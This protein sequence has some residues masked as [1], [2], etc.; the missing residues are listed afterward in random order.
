MA[1][2]ILP[3]SA[4]VR[5]FPPPGSQHAAQALRD[6]LLSGLNFTWELVPFLS[7]SRVLSL[8]HLWVWSDVIRDQ[9]RPHKE[10]N[11]LKRGRCKYFLP[12]ITGEGLRWCKGSKREGAGAVCVCVCVKLQRRQDLTWAV[13]EKSTLVFKTNHNSPH[14]PPGGASSPRYLCCL[15]GASQEVAHGPW[16]WRPDATTTVRRGACKNEVFTGQRSAEISSR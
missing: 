10:W 16:G 14:W 11:G 1:K 8:T 3:P 2:E 6:D 13:V 4:L 5:R 7:L 12:V 9:F 15:C